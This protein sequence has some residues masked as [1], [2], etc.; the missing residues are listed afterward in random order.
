MIQICSTGKNPSMRHMGRTHRVDAHWLHE[1]FQ[2]KWVALL[3]CGTHKMRADIFTKGFESLDKWAHAMHLI[4]HVSP[5][6]FFSHRPGD[7]A[8]TFVPESTSAPGG[9]VVGDI[10]K[11]LP[12]IVQDPTKKIA[13]CKSALRGLHRLISTAEWPKGGAL[14]DSSTVLFGA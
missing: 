5:D 1:T 10:A 12:A 13:L 11:A 3:K 9:G 14:N 4:N 6:S 7:E 8:I 2:Q